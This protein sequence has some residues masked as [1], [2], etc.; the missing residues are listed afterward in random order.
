MLTS[1]S[2]VAAGGAIGAVLRYFL[3]L[4]LSG[5]HGFPVATLAANIIGSFVL[6]CVV[7]RQTSKRFRLFLG[8]G[9]CGGFTTYSTFALEIDRLFSGGQPLFAFGYLA[10]SLLFGT[11]A[12]YLGVI[13]GGR[14]TKVSRT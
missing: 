1:F 7:G 9:I 4:A 13:I 10:I 11:L 2:L 8:T 14:A 12:A 6:G 3:A 5:W